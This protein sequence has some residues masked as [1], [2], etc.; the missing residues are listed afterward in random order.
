M[1]P[2]TDCKLRSQSLP[3]FT[4][5]PGPVPS[6]PAGCFATQIL[7]MPSWCPFPG[8]PLTLYSPSSKLCALLQGSLGGSSGRAFLRPNNCTLQPR[9]C[10]KHSA[11]PRW[12][13]PLP[14]TYS[15]PNPALRELAVQGGT[16]R[17]AGKI[18]SPDTPVSTGT[19]SP[20]GCTH[21]CHSPG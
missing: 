16:P 15:R 20:G 3:A 5:N 17:L 6:A 2:A 12:R 7:R 18:W 9:P 21:S 11:R 8:V 4:R 14:A 19:H 1:P 10:C 13:Q